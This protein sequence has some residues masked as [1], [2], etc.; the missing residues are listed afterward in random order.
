MS[1]T[2]TKSSNFIPYPILQAP[3]STRVDPGVHKEQSKSFSLRK[4]SPWFPSKLLLTNSTQ[5]SVPATL[6]LSCV[7][8]NTSVL[9]SSQTNSFPKSLT[10]AKRNE[11]CPSV[12]VLLHLV[13]NLA[14][15]LTTDPTSS[16]WPPTHLQ[17]VVISF[18]LSTPETSKPTYNWFP[19]K[20]LVKPGQ[21]PFSKIL[22]IFLFECVWL[23]P[24]AALCALPRNF[25]S[26]LLIS[27]KLPTSTEIDSPKSKSPPPTNQLQTQH[28]TLVASCNSSNKPYI[29]STNSEQI[30][31]QSLPTLDNP[32]ISSELYKL[33]STS[34]NHPVYVPCQEPRKGFPSFTHFGPCLTTSQFQGISTKKGLISNGIPQDV[35]SLLPT[36]QFLRTNPFPDIHCVAVPVYFSRTGHLA[37]QHYLPRMGS[38]GPAQLG[39]HLSPLK[40]PDSTRQDLITNLKAR[41]PGQGAVSN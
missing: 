2:T 41:A 15:L 40:N 8:K 18:N 11:V 26:I 33:F 5:L 7:A 12:A 9:P 16:R 21:L 36:S 39:L 1:I 19:L 25:Q 29:V 35:P 20:T 6:P 14:P 38:L 4:L 30:V 28:S 37:P 23:F 17:I 13:Q 32:E 22:I 31:S 34:N 3:S 27:R 10:P 24:M